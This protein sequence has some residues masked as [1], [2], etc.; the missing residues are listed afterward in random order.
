[1]YTVCASLVRS[2]LSSESHIASPDHGHA[3]CPAG[4]SGS[5]LSPGASYSASITHSMSR[6]CIQVLGFP[7]LTILCI[8][9]CV[10]PSCVM[11]PKGTLHNKNRQNQMNVRLRIELGVIKLSRICDGK[12]SIEVYIVTESYESQTFLSQFAKCSMIQQCSKCIE[13]LY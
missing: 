11:L 13:V 9:L 2:F 4:G 1:M 5:S 3:A 10:R 7:Q 6:L 8:L 12:N